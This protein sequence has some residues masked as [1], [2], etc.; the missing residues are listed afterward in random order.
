MFTSLRL[1]FHWQKTPPLLFLNV[2]EAGK[3]SL[4]MGSHVSRKKRRMSLEGQIVACNRSSETV[5]L[6]PILSFAL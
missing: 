1:T 2:E 4:Q 5:N 3:F 6:G